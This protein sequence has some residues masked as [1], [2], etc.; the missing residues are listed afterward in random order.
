MHM[1]ASHP[2]G[3]SAWSGALVDFVW[4]L[5]HPMGAMGAQGAGLRCVGS[6]LVYTDAS[7]HLPL[8][9]DYE[10]YVPPRGAAG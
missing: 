10:Y 5:R 1:Q 2:P 6:W 8:V 4:H 3:T 9:A 7:D